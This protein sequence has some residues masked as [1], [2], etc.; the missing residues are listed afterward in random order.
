MPSLVVKPEQAP[1]WTVA[2]LC[3]R[4][5]NT[6]EDYRSVFAAMAQARADLAFV[7]IDIEDD[8]DWMGDVDVENFPTL[9][10]AREGDLRFFGT[11][12]PHA[13][14][15]ERMVQA[16]LAGA[17]SLGAA[18]EAVHEL[19]QRLPDWLSQQLIAG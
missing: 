7:W 11:I 12:T 15:L 18:D 17:S 10:I 3:A 13:T 14:T 5:C 2:C 4:W 19:A 9:L 6:C 8:S 16:T 1:A